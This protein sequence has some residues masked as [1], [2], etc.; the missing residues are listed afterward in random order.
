MITQKNDDFLIVV[1]VYVLVTTLIMSSLG[2]EFLLFL[3]ST[4]LSI[5]SVVALTALGLWGVLEYLP[6]RISSVTRT[7]ITAFVSVIS[8]CVGIDIACW[9]L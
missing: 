2:V 5:G 4:F 6:H 7:L 3:F 8:T 1:I 9:F